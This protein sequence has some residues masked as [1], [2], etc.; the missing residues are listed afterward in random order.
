MVAEAAWLVLDRG[1]TVLND[2]SNCMLF[3]THLSED[4]FSPTDFSWYFASYTKRDGKW[5]EYDGGSYWGYEQAS[6]LT[7]AIADAVPYKDFDALAIPY[8]VF[9]DTCFDARNDFE[10]VRLGC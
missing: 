1:Y 7:N 9:E 2:S 5:L 6:D 4:S 8:S 3:E 10:V